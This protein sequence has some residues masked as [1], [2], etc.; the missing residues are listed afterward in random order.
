[1]GYSKYFFYFETFCL[2]IL[3][4]LTLCSPLSE[5]PVPSHSSVNMFQQ[6]TIEGRHRG[7]KYAHATIEEAVFSVSAV[8]SRSGGWWSRDTCLPEVHVV[9]SATYV[10]Q[11]QIANNSGRSTRTSKWGDT[12]GKFVVE[13]EPEVGL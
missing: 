2:V 13:E 8:T 9:S 12:H 1:M 7:P 10:K 4:G 5:Y 11:L 3:P 6:A